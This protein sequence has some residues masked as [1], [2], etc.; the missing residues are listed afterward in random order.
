[1]L[2]AMMMPRCIIGGAMIMGV[3]CK[4]L[5]PIPVP[6]PLVAGSIGALWGRVQ[7]MCHLCC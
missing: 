2:D 3:L 6:T 5:L 7:P 1:M 4:D